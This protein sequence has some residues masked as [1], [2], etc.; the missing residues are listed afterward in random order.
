ML[1]LCSKKASAWY[2]S[3]IVPTSPSLTSSPLRNGYLNILPKQ[4]GLTLEQVKMVLEQHTELYSSRVRQALAW[5]ETASSGE[6]WQTDTDLHQS[7]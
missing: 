6:S 5:A 2:C 7:D 4:A 1:I 3:T